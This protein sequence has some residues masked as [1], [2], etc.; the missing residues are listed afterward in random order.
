MLSKNEIKLIKLIKFTPVFI[1]A[2]VCVMVTFLLY[3]DKN[4]TLQADLKT[5]QNDYLKRN[6]N[7][8]KDEKYYYEVN[9]SN[10]VKR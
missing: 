7:I 6:E 4:I 5:L 8:I 1:V 3:V 2:L 9:I 10:H